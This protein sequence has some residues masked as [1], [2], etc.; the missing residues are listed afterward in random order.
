MISTG[1]G[2][3]TRITLS[4]VN[5]DPTNVDS[6]TGDDTF[7]LSGGTVTREVLAPLAVLTPT[8]STLLSGIGDRGNISIAAGKQ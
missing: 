5:C 6:G 8:G 2:A 1:G 4:G 7:T 3:D